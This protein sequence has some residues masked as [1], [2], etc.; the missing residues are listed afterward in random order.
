MS[1]ILHAVFFVVFDYVYFHTLVVILNNHD[2]KM[3][4]SASSQNFSSEKSILDHFEVIFLN[5]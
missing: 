1:T 2:Q 5:V 3:Q 4:F